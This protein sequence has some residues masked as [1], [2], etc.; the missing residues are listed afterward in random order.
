MPDAYTISL[1]LL[2]GLSVVSFAVGAGHFMQM[3][4][5]VRAGKNFL[6]Q[7]MGPFSLISSTLLDEDGLYHRRRTVTFLL[8]AMGFGAVFALVRS[9]FGAG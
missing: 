6:F 8:I 7:L 5:C 4:G 1:A 2:L 9:T 3:I